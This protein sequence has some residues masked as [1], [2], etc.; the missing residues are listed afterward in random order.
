M[1]IDR[2]LQPRSHWT[3]GLEEIR[4][5]LRNLPQILVAS[6]FDGTLSPIVAHPEK[7]ALEA[8][9][10]AVLRDLT[11][12]Y[13]E[14]RL[15]FLSGRSLTDLAPRL[16]AV[17]HNAI[18]AGNHGLEIRGP[19][20][21]WTHPILNEVRP[22]FDSLRDQLERIFR[23]MSGLEI[24]DKG[25]SLTLHYRR[26]AQRLV[27][28]LVERV[29]SIVVPGQIRIHEGK[30]VFEF[31]PKVNWNKGSAM[32]KI[33]RHLNLSDQSIIFLGDD[34]TDE[35]VFEELGHNSITVHVGSAEEASAAKWSAHDPSDA[36][37]F[38]S[39]VFRNSA[40]T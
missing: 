28:D 33:A 5:Q 27:P 39:Q 9:A 26:M 4:G 22:C 2:K 31:R 17:A 35:D 37:R 40:G 7:A 1:K 38:L 15:A 20:L 29:G 10:P 32:R 18:L 13:P 36:V 24:E 16:G 11:G 14:V 3:A 8:S 25:A 21:A 12:R 23:S 34:V 30:K 19:S 6:D